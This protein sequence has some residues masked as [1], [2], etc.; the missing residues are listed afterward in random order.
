MCD[1]YNWDDR[2]LIIPPQP[3][4]LQSPLH[5]TYQ[6]D[7]P[8]IIYCEKTGKYVAWL[9]NV[10]GD[11]S[12]FMTVLTADCFEGPYTVVRSIYKPLDM[13]SGDFYLHVDAQKKGI[14]LVRTAAF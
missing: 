1:L 7:R 3:D 8:H 6:M 2:G 9:K 14:Y 12:Q 10:G 13:D 5:P 4:N 11:I